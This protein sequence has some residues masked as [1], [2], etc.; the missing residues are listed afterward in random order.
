MAEIKKQSPQQTPAAK[1][2]PVTK[3]APAVKK[4]V[5][6]APQLFNKENYKWMI[7]GGAIIL[8]GMI[9]MSG[10]RSQDPNTFDPKVVYSTTRVTIAPILII[11]GLLVELYAILR[12][13]RQETNA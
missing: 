12:K 5:T 11:G 1:Q 9:L 4:P 2:A 3:Q 13:P 10:G 7:I 8:L 6:P